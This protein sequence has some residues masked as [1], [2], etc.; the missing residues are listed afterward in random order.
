MIFRVFFM[1]LALMLLSIPNARPSDALP[2]NDTDVNV[3][4]LKDRIV[5][6]CE[7]NELEQASCERIQLPQY[8]VHVEGVVK[9]VQVPSQRLVL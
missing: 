1:S 7:I 3:K 4:L 6:I 5:R 8:M 2:K 9:T